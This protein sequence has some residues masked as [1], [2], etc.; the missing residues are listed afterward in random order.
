MKIGKRKSE[1]ENQKAKIGKQNAQSYK[2]KKW[3]AKKAEGYKAIKVEGE[4]T[5][6]AE[7]P[8]KTI[9]SESIF[10]FHHL[11]FAFPF[12][13]PLFDLCFAFLKKRKAES[14]NWKAK[15]GKWKSCFDVKILMCFAVPSNCTL[16]RRL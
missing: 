2:R 3:R 8:E 1:S 13:V 6:K 10:C 9:L 12:P 5:Q 16:Q 14:E 4:K 11:I 15:S 7:D